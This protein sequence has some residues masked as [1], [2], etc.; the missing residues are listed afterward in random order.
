MIPSKPGTG[1]E[2]YSRS[3]YAD[4]WKLLGFNVLVVFYH[5]EIQE[6]KVY[7]L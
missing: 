2:N 3:R 6:H 7:F 5:L 1:W 4:T